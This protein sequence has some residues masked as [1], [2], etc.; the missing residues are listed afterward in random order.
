M[1]PTLDPSVV[2][3]AYEDDPL[4]ASAEYGAEFRNDIADFI[5]RAVVE[6]CVEP[7]VYERPYL[8]SRRYLAFID[9]SPAAPA[10][11]A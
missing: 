8:R 4:S 10:A 6:A 1:N 7:G 11:T 9:A 5:S 3:R 2:E